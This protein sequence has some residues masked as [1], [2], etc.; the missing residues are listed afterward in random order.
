MILKYNHS[1]ND[2]VVMIYIWNKNNYEKI[3]F[4]DYI[5]KDNLFHLVTK[6]NLVD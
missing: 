4:V 1:K 2:M 6:V 3:N 5:K